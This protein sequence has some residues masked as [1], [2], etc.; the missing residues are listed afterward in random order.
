PGEVEA[1][2]KAHPGVRACAVVAREHHA[3]ARL[4][5]Y[6]VLQEDATGVAALRSHLAGRLPE[7]MVP[8]AFIVLEALPLAPNGK[9]ARRALP[10]PDWGRDPARRRPAAAASA[11]E[12]AL[13][14]IWAKVLQV[15]EVGPDDNFFELGGDS[16][17]SIQ[18]VARARDAGLHLTPRR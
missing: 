10:P 1:V 13:G 14:E 17:L 16:I 15:E 7:D 4:V 11:A 6:I 3:G 2:L 5:A 9:I 18:V 8:S 12:R